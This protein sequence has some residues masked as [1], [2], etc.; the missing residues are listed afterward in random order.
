M[1][2]G[3]MGK[4]MNTQEH[5]QKIRSELAA[6]EALTPEPKTMNTQEH[7]QK[8]KLEL[9]ALE[10]SL[11]SDPKA[12]TPETLIA[13]IKDFLSVNRDN[14][15][16]VELCE[17]IIKFHTLGDTLDAEDVWQILEDLQTTANNIA[18]LHKH[19]YLI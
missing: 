19:L 18:A 6:I 10:A 4:T 17:D 5:I 1:S 3:N 8:I 13:K 14:Q 16:I 9:A 15:R 2:E 7:I 12:L 11:T